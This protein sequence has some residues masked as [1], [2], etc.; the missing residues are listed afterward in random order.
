MLMYELLHCS[1]LSARSYTKDVSTLGF[2][3]MRSM[4]LCMASTGS[5]SITQPCFRI[6]ASV[7]LQVRG[8]PKPNLMKDANELISAV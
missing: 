1:L 8:F 4:H 5:L 2:S 7:L 3:M 6:T